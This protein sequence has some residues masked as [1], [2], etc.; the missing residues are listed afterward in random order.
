MFIVY[1][2]LLMLAKF[3]LLRIFL[4]TCFIMQLLSNARDGKKF[5][6]RN[7]VPYLAYSSVLGGAGLFSVTDLT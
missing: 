5:C 6:Q 4:K 7:D 1:T 3:S 2:S